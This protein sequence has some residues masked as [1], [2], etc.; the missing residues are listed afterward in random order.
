MGVEIREINFCILNCCWWFLDVNEILGNSGACEPHVERCDC[1]TRHQRLFKDVQ[2]KT[3][4]LSNLRFVFQNSILF[5]YCCFKDRLKP[6]Y[7]IQWLA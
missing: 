7:T 4:E 5:F 2:E 1:A 3:K 6:M